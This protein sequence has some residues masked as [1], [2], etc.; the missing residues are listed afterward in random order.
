MQV[1]HFLSP[2]WFD[3]IPKRWIKI[4]YFVAGNGKTFKTNIMILLGKCTVMYGILL[5]YQLSCS[6]LV[7]RLL[8]MMKFI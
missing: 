7:V 2:Y 1:R 5:F 8:L 3:C 4:A 6:V